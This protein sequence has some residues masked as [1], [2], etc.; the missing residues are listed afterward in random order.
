MALPVRLRT[1]QHR[2]VAALVETDIRRLRPDATANLDVARQTNAA[3]AAGLL[4]GLGAL[5]KI[6]PVGEVLRA[7][8][9]SGEFA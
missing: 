3:N 7:L 4:G 9:M 1:D 2:E 6:L 5:G 8:Q